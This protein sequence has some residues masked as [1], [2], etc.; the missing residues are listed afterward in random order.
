MEVVSLSLELCGGV[1][2]IRHDAGDGLMEEV[3]YQ[4]D[5]SVLLPFQHSPSTQPSSGGACHRH[6]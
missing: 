4:E 3:V 1:D 6:P 2:L 5:R